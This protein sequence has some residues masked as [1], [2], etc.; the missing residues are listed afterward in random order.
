VFVSSSIR[1]RE[2]KAGEADDTSASLAAAVGASD[3]LLLPQGAVHWD[4]A[5]GRLLGLASGLSSS[6]GLPA[7]TARVDVLRTAALTQTLPE[8]A[9]RVQV[10]NLHQTKGR[11]ADTTVVLVQEGVYY[12]GEVEPFPRRQPPAL[13]G[14]D[15]SPQADR[16][17]VH[18][19]GAGRQGHFPHPPG[20][21]CG[22]GAQLSDLR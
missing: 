12:G 18:G 14:A 20:R 1:S 15:T 10:M 13:R 6:G 22:A 11:E 2:Q 4:Q 9:A 17:Q 16:T 8:P 21:P 19:G 7:L 3:R 5:A